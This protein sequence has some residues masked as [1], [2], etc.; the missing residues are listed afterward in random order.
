MI[1]FPTYFLQSQKWSQ[2]W[3]KAN[4]EGH[5]VHFFQSYNK[6]LFCYVYQYPWFFGKKFW[7]IPKA[8]GFTNTNVSNFEN[9]FLELL[10]NIKKAGKKQ[11][12]NFVKI[13][14]DSQFISNLKALEIF[15]KTNLKVKINTKTIQYIKTMTLDLSD[16]L[17]LNLDR[18][19]G[20]NLTKFY[21][22]SDIFWKQTNQ[23]IRRY[24][25]KS[26]TKNW[27]ISLEKTEQN[28]EIF[29]VLYNDTKNRQNFA[30]QEKPYLKELFKQDFCKIIIL[31]DD[32]DK[33]HSGWF[34]ITSQNTLTYLYGA[35]SEA[36]FKNYGQYLVHLVAV[37]IAV[38]ENLRF[39]DLGGYDPGLGFGK[40]KEGYR[41]QIREFVGPFDLIFKQP[42]YLLINFIIKVVKIFKK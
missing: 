17:D 11:N 32:E 4:R 13:D 34:G 18:K 1:K 9:D 24:T 39:Y 23:N 27:K 21:E 5:D 15:K 40:F 6:N 41:G 30:I 12:I 35:N 2:F 26:L 28:F 25:K 3:L 19:Q 31:Y 36:S 20:L 38:K 22:E 37:Q 8:P 7:Y 42:E 33:P 10:E 29:W 16:I 14:L